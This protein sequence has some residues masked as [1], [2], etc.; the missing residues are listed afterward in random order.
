MRNSLFFLKGLKEDLTA[1]LGEL[2]GTMLLV[3]FGLGGVQAIM[4]SSPANSPSQVIGIATSF[5][6]AVLVSVWV[7][8]RV[9]GAALNPAVVLALLVTKKITFRRS[10]LYLVTEIVGGIT[11]AGFLHLLTP[12]PLLGLNAVSDRITLAQAVF[13]EMFLILPLILTVL[14]LAVEKSR[15]TFLAPVAI[16][17]AVFLAHLVGM[18]FTGTGI[19]PARSFGPAVVT[20]SFTSHH[21]VFWVGPFLG[22]LI[23]SA[24]YKVFV[25][26]QYIIE[27][28]DAVDDNEVCNADDV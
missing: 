20:G 7:F 11:G 5:G 26:L 18:P 3:F 17:L 14:F 24:I 22:S 6:L 2:F 15:T 16:G 13:L 12:G 23:G 4:S 25:T 8:F 28:T 21:W 9:S 1:S 19:N 10:V 27:K